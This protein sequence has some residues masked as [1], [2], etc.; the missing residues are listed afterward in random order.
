MSLLFDKLTLDQLLN[1]QG[2]T[3]D[4]YHQMYS[5]FVGSYSNPGINSLYPKSDFAEMLKDTD[6]EI[7]WNDI[8]YKIADKADLSSVIETVLR[9]YT[10]VGTQ[11]PWSNYSCGVIRLL[12]IYDDWLGYFYPN[13]SNSNEI[14]EFLKSLNLTPDQLKDLE[15]KSDLPKDPEEE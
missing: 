3:L 7:Y 12:Q 11:Y 6:L 14:K 8:S 4:Q 2:Y 5:F 15:K 9:L 1:Q 13:R 10:C